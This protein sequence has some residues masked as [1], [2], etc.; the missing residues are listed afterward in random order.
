M[1]LKRTKLIGITNLTGITPN[2]IGIFT[3]GTTQTSSGVA[4]TTYIRSIVTHNTSGINTAA[5]SIYIAPNGVNASSSG[6]NHLISQVNLNPTET[7][8]FDYAYPLVLEN[9]DK[10]AINIT[11]PV[12]GA[13]GVGTGTQMNVQIL[14]DTV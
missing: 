9:G 5:C 7:Y 11:H 13:T 1:G 12:M 3:S 8:F 14:G 2:P 6:T 10:I 4:G